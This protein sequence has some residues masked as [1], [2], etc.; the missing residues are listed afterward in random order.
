MHEIVKGKVRSRPS[1]PIP[2]FGVTFAWDESEGR[3]DGRLGVDPNAQAAGLAR[4]TISSPPA[5]VEPMTG[6][7]FSSP[8]PMAER[9]PSP[10]STRA[11]ASLAINWA[12]ATSTERDGWGEVIA[13]IREAASQETVIAS[14][15][16][17]RRR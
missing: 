2:E 13:S 8:R 11:P 9:S 7:R 16:T 1:G 14:E 17:H 5:E 12:A 3:C 15:P 10:S 4:R 6:N